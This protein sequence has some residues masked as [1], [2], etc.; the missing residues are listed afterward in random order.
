MSAG[1]CGWSAGEVAGEVAGE[2]LVGEGDVDQVSAEVARG[3]SRK[4]A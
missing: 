2:A 4:R 3:Q 1:E